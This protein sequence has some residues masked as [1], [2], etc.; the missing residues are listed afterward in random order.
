MQDFATK[1]TTTKPTKIETILNSALIILIIPALAYA[2][3]FSYNGG[4]NSFYGIPIFLT[5]ASGFLFLRNIPA[6]T[7]ILQIAISIYCIL[8]ICVRIIKLRTATVDNDIKK[9]RTSLKR[10]LITVSVILFLTILVAIYFLVNKNY[11]LL[12]IFIYAIITCILCIVIILKNLSIY[13]D[14]CKLTSKN[15]EQADINAILERMESANSSSK[16]L[17]VL[18]QL[19]GHGGC[20]LLYLAFFL[21][22]PYYI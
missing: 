10:I 14:M 19:L 2:L 15:I 13:N 8:H 22:L 17:L 7:T 5:D 18:F 21:H 3:S 12:I 16:K 4:Y 1:E 20:W 6:L 9:E 11:V